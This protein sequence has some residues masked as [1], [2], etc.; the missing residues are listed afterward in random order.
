MLKEKIKKF[1]KDK[2][3]GQNFLIDQNVLQKIV[4]YLGNETLQGDHGE[5][6]L[7]YRRFLDGA[8]NNLF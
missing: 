6:I 2:S 8:A 4:V 7:P 3:Y 5:K 1:K